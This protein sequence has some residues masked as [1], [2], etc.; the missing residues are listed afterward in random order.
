[1][2]E[3]RARTVLIVD[4]DFL[5]VEYLR[6]VVADFGYVV[7]GTAATAG[8]AVDA[9][10]AL[11]PDLILMDVRL[12]GRRDG[13]DAAV[14]IHTEMGVPI[15]FITGSNEPETIAR[16]NEDSPTGVLIKPIMPQHLKDA[17]TAALA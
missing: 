4:D 6:D 16:I 15:I 17:L 12:R 9:A 3:A 14:Q 7:A 13:V 5:I 2:T 1:M 11:Q 10:R 8:A